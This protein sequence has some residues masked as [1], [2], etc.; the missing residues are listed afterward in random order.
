[1]QGRTYRYGTQDPLYPFGFGLSY[2]VFEYEGLKLSKKHLRGGEPLSLTVQLK[3]TGAVDAEEVV[4]VYLSDLE[5]SVTVPVNKLVGFRRVSVKAG[6]SKKLR[7]TL[8]S[9]AMQL[10]DEDGEPRLE[11]GEFRLTVGGCSPGPRGQA[12]GAPAP[13]IA[14]FSVSLG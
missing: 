9:D 4:Q 6:R 2:T 10:I 8:P 7:F 13:Q 5:A 12:L 1:M 14:Y 3:N 11:P